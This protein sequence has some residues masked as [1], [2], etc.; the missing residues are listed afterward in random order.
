MTLSPDNDKYSYN[1]NS[2]YWYALQTKP[3]QEFK[4]EKQ[5]KNMGIENY[6]PVIVKKNSWSDRTKIILLSY[7]S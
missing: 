2:K 4:A 3:R 5:L 7:L 1:N 6:L